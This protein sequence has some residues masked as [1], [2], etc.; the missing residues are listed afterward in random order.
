MD[1]IDEIGPTVDDLVR[2]AEH[3]YVYDAEF[4]ARAHMAVRAAEESMRGPFTNWERAIAI[5]AATVA[6]VVDD[7][8]LSGRS[9]EQP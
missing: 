6:L 9:G 1:E 7:L 5:R 2:R 3:G 4:H 8:D